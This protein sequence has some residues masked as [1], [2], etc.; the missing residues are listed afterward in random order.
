MRQLILSMNEGTEDLWQYILENISDSALDEIEVDRDI[1]DPSSLASEPVTAALILSLS[2]L[3]AATI[4][5]LVERWMENKKQH[6]QLEI[7][8]RGFSISDEAR[9]AAASL[10]QKHAD[11]SIKYGLPGLPRKTN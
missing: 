10:A 11:V 4:L 2:S 1:K 6:E 3:T 7:V 5:R 9:K 8:L